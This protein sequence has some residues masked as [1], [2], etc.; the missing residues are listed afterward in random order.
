MAFAGFP[1]RPR[2]TPVPTPVLGQLLEEIDDLQ[3]LKVTLRAI[4]L[5]HHKRTY[6]RYLTV[7]DLMTDQTCLR[8]F[9]PG[10]ESA[11][12]CAEETM[13][14]AVSR[15]TFIAGT[16]TIDGARTQVFM[17][18]AESERRAMEGLTALPRTTP[19]PQVSGAASPADT[20]AAEDSR[21]NIFKLYEDNIGLMSPMIAE[22]LKLAEQ[23]YP[24]TW[25]R[26]AFKAA[27]TSNRRSW[28]Y[29]AA[30]LD[31]W[32]REG[33]EGRDDAGPGRYIQ[34]TRY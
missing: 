14:K 15:R 31:R 7:D 25:I 30:I 27:V 1:P 16:A 2:Y 10:A 13:A 26:D 22:E 9:G 17:L 34:K 33:R 4:W 6:P 8:V 23:S 32:D 12:R 21:P 5:L 29:I 18:N 19:S 20:D 11:R 28:R 3:E 24:E